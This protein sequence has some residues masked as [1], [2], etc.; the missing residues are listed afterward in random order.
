[1]LNRK[2]EHQLRVEAFMLRAS[3]LLGSQQEVPLAPTEPTLEVR[4]LRAKLILEE[5]LETIENGL[6]LYVEIQ[7]DTNHVIFIE[8]RTKKFN[9]AE[10]IDGC[11]DIAV[12]TTGTLS[13]CGIPDLPFQELVDE[14]NLQKFGPG[15]SI[16]EDGKLIKPP[17]HQPPD[18]ESVLLDLGIPSTKF[19]VNGVLANV[20]Y[21]I[22]QPG[23]SLT[24]PVPPIVHKEIPYEP[25]RKISDH[26]C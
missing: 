25:T 3:K 12:V 7:P 4:K 19:Y 13:A 10:V 23:L 24:E 17:G 2:S 9:L 22:T 5:A 15:C 8:H 21:G 16:R 1:M 14:N 20:K 26:V 6:G 18:I 11:C